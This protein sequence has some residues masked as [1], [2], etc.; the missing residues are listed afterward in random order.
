MVGQLFLPSV[1]LVRMDLVALRNSATV[2]CSRSASRAIFAVSAVS[3]F[4]LVFFVI[5]HSVY[6]TKQPVSNLP[7]VPKTGSTSAVIRDLVARIVLTPNAERTHL[8]IDLH[9]DLAGILT[10][11]NDKKPQA[12]A[13]GAKSLKVLDEE[14]LSAVA[15][16]AKS[17][18]VAGAGFEPAAFRL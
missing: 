11:A 2:A 14:A 1:D 7:I 5:A 18:M 4:R 3:I 16:W 8:M 10:I 9:G 17:K 6:L 13:G 15:G 12:G